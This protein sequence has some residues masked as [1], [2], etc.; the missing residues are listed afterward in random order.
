[1]VWAVARPRRHTIPLL[2]GLERRALSYFAG[3]LAVHLGV[4]AI[5][6]LLPPEATGLSV[7]LHEDEEIL[8]RLQGTTKIAP[9]PERTDGSGSEGGTEG[10]APMP[11]PSGAAGKPNAINHGHLQIAK[12]DTP[13]STA[14]DIEIERARTA[15]VLGVLGVQTG[16]RVLGPS[17]ALASGIDAESF[18]GPLYGGDG[19]GPGVFG[20][21]P[22]G[23]DV[24]GGC[25]S[26]SC[27]TLPSGNRYGNGNRIGS[28]HRRGGDYNPFGASTGRI[29][30]HQPNPPV[31]KD[32]TI[33]GSYDKSI[34]RRY[35]R[36][37]I[38]KIGYCYDKEL[39]AHPDI[40]G[41]ITVSFFI[42]PTGV[43]QHSSGSGF[44]TEVAGC[45]ASV[46]G[47]I[48]FPR[49]GEMAA[50]G[51]QVTYPFHFHAAGQPAS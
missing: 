22:S 12:A 43:V 27:G 10:G 29:S 46:I 17:E 40:A 4:W 8:T 32:P 36:R 33:G 37:N 19:E 6:Q 7:D 23:V 11:L 24:G 42:L 26:D 51:V 50:G 20:G 16:I 31:M 48:E 5:L 41:A 18:N 34:I 25:M 28:W 13:L 9:V 1:V 3:S 44:D 35:I 15:G 14:R 49:P 45:V 21:A 2:A 30:A 47:S 39:L 38:D